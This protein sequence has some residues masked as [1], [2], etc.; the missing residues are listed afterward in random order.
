MKIVFLR[1]NPVNPDS[2]VEKE[3]NSLIKEGYSIQ[4]IA[5]DRTENYPIKSELL[6]LA[7]GSVEIFRFGIKASFGGGFKTNLMPLLKFQGYILKWLVT[8]R[9]SYD[10]IHACD[11]DTAYVSLKVA[12]LYN[13]K[14]VYDIFDY[15]T[16]SFSVPRILKRFIENRD[17]NVI[18]KA[19]KVII[20]SEKRKEQLKDSNPK[21]LTILHNT[22]SSNLVT[23]NEK[24]IKLNENKIKVVYIGILGEGRM[25]L[26]IAK[27]IN[28]RDDCELHIAGFGPLEH[29]MKL[30]SEESDS[31][32]YYGKLS[33]EQAIDLEKQ[34]DIMTAIY[35]PKVNNHKYAAPNKFYEALFLGKPIIVVKG[36]SIDE[37]VYKDDLGEVIEFNPE[38]F[39]LAL[40]QLINRKHDWPE[41]S[42]KSKHL[43]SYLYS[44]E[45]MEKRLFRMYKEL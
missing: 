4:I 41:I 3:V 13:K 16:D 39:N 8:N 7:N 25:I 21:S 43:Y 32:I 20:C 14:L 12:K 9:S 36:T 27:I 1:S 28:K 6:H 23:A 10:V 38:A 19:D 26:E 29:S 31:I 44:W 22:P 15:Y 40:T 34:C 18:N 24:R 17:R 33:Y 37:I 35:D 30:L 2:R 11:F 5:W 42:R 45:E